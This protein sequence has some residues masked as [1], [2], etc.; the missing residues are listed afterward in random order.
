PRHGHG[1]HPAQRR[2]HPARR[3]RRGA[4]ARRGPLMTAADGSAERSAA[5]EARIT[6]LTAVV[7]GAA[8]PR[9]IGRGVALRLAREGRPLALLDLEADGLAAVAEE[10]RA[11]GA[12]AVVTAEADIADEDSVD[13]AIARVDAADV[14]PIG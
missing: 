14:P 10:A 8:S 11:A 4:H 5:D 12:P 3:P 6:E 9:G 7:T 1:S 13:A 2:Q